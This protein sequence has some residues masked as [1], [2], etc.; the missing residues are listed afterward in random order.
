MFSHVEDSLV[1]YMLRADCLQ[2]WPLM[3]SSDENVAEHTF[4]VAIIAHRLAAY[5][6]ALGE[7]ID[8]NSVAVKALFHEAAEM[9]GVGDIPGPLKRATPE[10]Y[11]AVKAIEHSTEVSMVECLSSEYM[12]SFYRDL[13]VQEC[14]P[15][16]EKQIVKFADEIQMLIKCTREVGSGNSEFCIAKQRQSE[17]VADLVERHKIV[18]CFMRT[19]FM[20]C[21]SALDN[22]QK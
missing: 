22:L 10:M 1:A 6:L 12:R 7:D 16:R 18:A 19:D 15:S 9:G 13:V 21:V 4:G 14:V 5:A 8:P 11:E 3:Y 2:R 17:L 20:L